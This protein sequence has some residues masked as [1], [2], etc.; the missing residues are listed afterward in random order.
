[1]Q[2]LVS[3]RSAEEAEA[4][5]D[6]GAG[7]IDVKEP[8][9]GSLGPADPTVIS[10]VLHVVAGRAPVSAALGELLDGPTDLAR[11]ELSFVK[12]GLAGC[13]GQDWSSALRQAQQLAP[14][15]PVA[16]AYADWSRAGA[17]APSDV[18][19][20]AIA[21]SWAAFLLDTWRKD[22]TTLLDWLSHAGLAE[23]RTRCRHAGVPVALAGSLGEAEIRELM[24]LQPDWFAVRGAACRCG[25]RTDRIDANR[26]RS[27]AEL[28]MATSPAG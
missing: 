18:C 6:G 10:E 2:L 20:F 7:L 17:P 23:L 4:A 19:D 26:V 15:R 28:L 1:M 27:L 11:S 21:H 5:L 14:C 9:R 3:V 8:A 13:Q 16:V 12:W 24:V 25:R 22:G